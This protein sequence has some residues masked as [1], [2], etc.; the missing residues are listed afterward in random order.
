MKIYAIIK[1]GGKQYKVTPGKTV[2]VDT[3][4]VAEGNQVDLTDVLLIADGDKVSIGTPTIAG[5]KVVATALGEERGKKIIVFKYKPKVRYRRMKGHRQTYTRLAV[6]EI[7][8]PEASGE[9]ERGEN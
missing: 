7:V 3:L 9:P 6:K 8:Q 2:S 5:A 1:S 4:S